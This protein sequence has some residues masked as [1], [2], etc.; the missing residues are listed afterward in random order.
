MC[1][2]TYYKFLLIRSQLFLYKLMKVD[3]T[4][5]SKISCRKVAHRHKQ[6]ENAHPNKTN[7]SL[8]FYARD[9]NLKPRNKFEYIF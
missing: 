9:P 7:R 5:R 2:I 3:L 4:H 6:K 8:A 1:P